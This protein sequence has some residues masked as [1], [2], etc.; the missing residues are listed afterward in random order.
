MFRRRHLAN[1]THH[2][3]GLRSLEKGAD[4]RFEVLW[5]A[6]AWFGKARPAGQKRCCDRRQI[7]ESSTGYSSYQPNDLP[8]PL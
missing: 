1:G 8:V 6:C 2:C 4:S 5:L 7:I 3:P